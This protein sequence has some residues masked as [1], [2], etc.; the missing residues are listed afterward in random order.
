[1]VYVFEKPVAI[2]NILIGCVC[3]CVV[4]S[5][6]SRRCSVSIK[7]TDIML[8]VVLCCDNYVQMTVYGSTLNQ[9]PRNTHG[10]YWIMYLWLC[11]IHLSVKVG[12]KISSVP[13]PRN[14]VWKNALE[15][16]NYDFFHPSGEE[17]SGSFMCTHIYILHKWSIATHLALPHSKLLSILAY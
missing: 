3:V 2:G 16:I 9:S 1:M 11:S 15:L 17:V 4:E 14:G 7:T 5:V 8:L 12:S 6:F 13:P 10:N